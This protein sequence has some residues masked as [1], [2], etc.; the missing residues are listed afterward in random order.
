MIC[1]VSALILIA[2]GA[3]IECGFFYGEKGPCSGGNSSEV[4][5]AVL[6]RG[7]LPP[8]GSREA[9]RGVSESLARMQRSGNRGWLPSSP[10]ALER[11]LIAFP[12]AQDKA[13]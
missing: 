11:R 8:T 9:N 7:R 1:S 6:Q 10:P 3:K 2:I 5:V 13:S 12:K 4:F